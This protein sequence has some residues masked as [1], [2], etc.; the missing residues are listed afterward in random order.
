MSELEDVLR[1]LQYT[2]RPLW[3]AA[4]LVAL[5]NAQKASKKKLKLKDLWDLPWD[6]REVSNSEIERAFAE[7]QTLQDLINNQ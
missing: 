2:N 6:D 5:V 1:N 7:Q 4:R 3:D